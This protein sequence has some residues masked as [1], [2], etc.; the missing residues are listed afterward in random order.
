MPR[1]LTR[2]PPARADEKNFADQR[3]LEYALWHNH[4]IQTHRR[5]LAEVA[6]TGRI[7]GAAR[8]LVVDGVLVGVCYFR[9]G[10]T[11]RDFP[12]EAEWEAL[13]LMERS[14]AILCPSTAFHLAGKKKIQ[15][16][17]SMPGEAAWRAI[18]RARA[19]R[20]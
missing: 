19:Q 17:V 18:A 2:P 14:R 9:A 10:Y 11:P 13:R 20:V 3:W 6:A 12:G 7:E 16:V 4:G 15:Q 5:T 1:P 8:D